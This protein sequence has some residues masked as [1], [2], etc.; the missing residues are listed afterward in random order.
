[1]CG[2]GLLI[3]V[4]AVAATSMRPHP[5][6]PIFHSGGVAQA[7]RAGGVRSRVPRAQCVALRAPS[8]RLL[9]FCFAC[10]FRGARC[11]RLDSESGSRGRHATSTARSVGGR[12]ARSAGAPVPAALTRVASGRRHRLGPLRVAARGARKRRLRLGGGAGAGE[13]ALASRLRHGC[14]ECFV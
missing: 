10:G 5:A 2:P 12:G 14:D 13:R 3:V 8:L 9:F 6:H 11:R 7:A 4:L 1:M